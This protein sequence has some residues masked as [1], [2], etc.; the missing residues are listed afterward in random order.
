MIGRINLIVGMGALFSAA[1]LCGCSG[2][3]SAATPPATA[4]APK[5]PATGTAGGPGAGAAQPQM[6]PKGPDGSPP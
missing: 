4:T 2:G 5:P 6:P 1:I 3:D